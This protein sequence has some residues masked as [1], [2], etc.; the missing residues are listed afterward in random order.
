MKK[1]ALT[2]CVATILGLSSGTVAMAATINSAG[3]RDSHAV[4]GTYQPEGEAATVYSVDVSW[5]SMEFTYTDGAVSKIWNPSTHQY[6]ESVGEG[7]WSNQDGAN[8]VT[9]TNRSNK[10][11][12][13]T[14][15]AATSGSYT[16]ITAKVN[17]ASL[18]LADASIGAST[19][20]AGTA[21]TASTTISLS[22]AL[23][24]KTANKATIG[25]VT[26][27]IA[28]ADT[29]V[30]FSKVT[31]SVLSASTSSLAMIETTVLLSN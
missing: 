10:A 21:S 27:K 20:V 25:S 2:L 26:V 5:G 1:K 13:A 9:V 31:I 30:P 18:S 22:G 14:V 24:D 16:G 11:L 28:D 17:N 23:T 12:T 6:T 15:E 8:K 19:T 3:G 29:A 4:Y 7:S